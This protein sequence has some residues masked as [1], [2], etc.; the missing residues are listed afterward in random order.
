MNP[1]L[2]P[3]TYRLALILLAIFWLPVVLICFGGD[4]LLGYGTFWGLARLYWLQTVAF[5]RHDLWQELRHS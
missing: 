1:F 2:G 4:V 3:M 5:W